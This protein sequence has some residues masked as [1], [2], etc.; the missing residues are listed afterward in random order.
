MTLY[1]SS[2]LIVSKTLCKQAQHTD[3][4]MVSYVV[5]PVSQMQSACMICTRLNFIA[6]AAQ[7]RAVCYGGT[8]QALV[9]C[10]P[11]MSRSVVIRG[12][13]LNRKRTLRILASLGA[14]SQKPICPLLDTPCSKR[15]VLAAAS[16]SMYQSSQQQQATLMHHGT[17]KVLYLC[18]VC[19]LL[20]LCVT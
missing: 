17:I 13:V 15:Q 5:T 19:S 12:S 2:R 16:Q 6:N 7:L 4:F 1:G 11:T 18:A 20:L 8:Q 3:S 14:Q 10:K 9:L